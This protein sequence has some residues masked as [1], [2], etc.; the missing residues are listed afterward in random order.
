MSKVGQLEWVT[1]NRA[2]KLFQEKLDYR[3]LGNWENREDNSNIEEDILT[4]YLKKN[5]SDNEGIAYGAIGTKEKY[6]LKWKEVNEENNP[7]DKHLL[8][9]T[10]PIRQL[11]ATVE[12]RLDKNI[13]EMLNKKRFLELI[14]DNIVFDRGIKKLSRPNQYF[15]VKAAQGHIKKREGGIIWHTQGSGKSL[16][17]VWLTKWIRKNIKNARVLVITDRVELDEQIEKVYKG[18]NQ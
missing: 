18:V 5:Y 3:Y 9:L 17:M 14:H 4:D 8:E 10:Q 7:N 2:V 13:I 12:H 6:Y 11:A 15:G 16:T 1:Q